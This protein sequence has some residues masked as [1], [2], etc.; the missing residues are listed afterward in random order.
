MPG[1]ARALVAVAAAA[2][3]AL[4]VAGVLCPAAWEYSEGDAATWIWLLR[5]GRDIYAAP[6]GLPMWSSNYPPLYL[7][8]IARLAPSDGSILLVGRLVSLAGYLLATAMVGLSAR[9][10]TR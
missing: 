2:T 7:H 3:L 1:W 8:L 5:H 4:F 10:A 9:A 6:S